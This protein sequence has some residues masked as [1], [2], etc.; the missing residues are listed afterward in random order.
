M[1]ISDVLNEMIIR[2]E[3]YGD[4]NEIWLIAFKENIW[5]FSTDAIEEVESDTYDADLVSDILK[6]TGVDLEN[7][8]HWD[9]GSIRPDVLVGMWDKEEG[10]MT[11]FA[12]DAAQQHPS[13]STLI[14]KVAKQLNV[15]HV[16]FQTTWDDSYD[17]DNE[18]V[19]DRSEL[20][21]KIPNVMYH[22]TSSHAMWSIRRTGIR[23]VEKSNWGN[24]K[25]PNVVFMTTNAKYAQFHAAN[26]SEKIQAMP[27]IIKFKIPNKNSVTF[28]YDVAADMYGE[29]H[30]ELKNTPYEDSI[31]HG[32]DRTYTRYELDKIRAFQKGTNIN[33]QLGIFGYKGRIPASHIIAVYSPMSEEPESDLN[34]WIE[35]DGKDALVLFGDAMEMFDTWGYYDEDWMGMNME[36]VQAEYFDEDDDE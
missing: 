35:F 9:I 2:Q 29:G 36:E 27:V 19:F 14:K 26:A 15:R 23:P 7:T 11:I 3:K 8:E 17:D 31:Y 4:T 6:Y 5:L 21:G 28:D 32:Q 10:S 12:N 20:L 16:G 13:S 1:K 25:T 24:L 33:T 18:I 22:G 34:K 30:P